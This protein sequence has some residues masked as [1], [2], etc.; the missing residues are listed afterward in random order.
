MMHL[1]SANGTNATIVRVGDSAAY[2]ISGGTIYANGQ[3]L[4]GTLSVANPLAS[5]DIFYE[6]KAAD[7]VEPVAYD[8][9]GITL[10]AGNFA[11]LDVSAPVSDTSLVWSVS[12]D[13]PHRSKTVS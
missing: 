11:G 1:F 6:G 4:E 8:A 10:T 3:P 5:F 12:D 13:T 2:T 7:A 9:G